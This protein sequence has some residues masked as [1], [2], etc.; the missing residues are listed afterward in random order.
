MPEREDKGS[1][2]DFGQ[3]HRK[4]EMN[5]STLQ[6]KPSIVKVRPLLLTPC[7][8]VEPVTHFSNTSGHD[9]QMAEESRIVVY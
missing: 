2:L 6:S 9:K 4:K 8:F 1:H 5:F 7:P 3:L